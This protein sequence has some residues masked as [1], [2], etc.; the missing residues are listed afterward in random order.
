VSN[1]VP[2]L[3]DSAALTELDAPAMKEYAALIAS[4]AER[5]ARAITK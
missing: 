2:P 4:R 1:Q 5:L 3:P